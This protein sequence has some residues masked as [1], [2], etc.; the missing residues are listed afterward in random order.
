MRRIKLG[1]IIFYLIVIA[2][3]T[4]N[5]ESDMVKFLFSGYSSTYDVVI[6][7]HSPYLI[8]SLAALVILLSI[9]K[10]LKNIIW[11]KYILPFAIF[12]WVLSMRTAAYV[13]TD[14]ILVSGWSFIRINSYKCSTKNETG[15][16]S[17]VESCHI[18]FD[19]FLNRRIKETASKVY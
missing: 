5:Y 19:P 18:D 1:Q 11:L 13:Y 2:L 16:K 9:A 15:G 17:E 7:R 12:C 14:G 4:I 3:S 10:K 6:I 8:I